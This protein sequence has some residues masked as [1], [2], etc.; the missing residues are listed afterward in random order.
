MNRGTL[1]IAAGSK[2][3]HSVILVSADGAVLLHKKGA[4]RAVYPLPSLRPGVYFVAVSVDGNR[5][6]KAI[7]LDH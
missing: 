5:I 1:S 2:R 4:G 7:A 6:R 3:T